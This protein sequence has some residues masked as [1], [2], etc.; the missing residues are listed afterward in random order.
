MVSE[1]QRATAKKPV[2]AAR[3]CINIVVVRDKRL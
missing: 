3:N 1:A 2:E